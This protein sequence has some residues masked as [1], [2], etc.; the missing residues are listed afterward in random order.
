MEP[1]SEE[2]FAALVNKAILPSLQPDSKRQ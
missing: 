2:E 1:I